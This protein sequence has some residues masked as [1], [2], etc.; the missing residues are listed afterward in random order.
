MR[1]ISGTDLFI[2]LSC[3]VLQWLF[4]LFLISAK[5]DVDVET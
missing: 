1:E 5:A 3:G 2:K 4:V